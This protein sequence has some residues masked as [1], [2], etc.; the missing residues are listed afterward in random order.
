M[1]G[2]K[3]STTTKMEDGARNLLYNGTK[4]INK[5]LTIRKLLPHASIIVSTEAP[6]IQ[7]L[8][9]LGAKKNPKKARKQT[10]APW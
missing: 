2:N 4:S 7:N 10:T 3:S 8:Y 5:S 6:K 1:S 9:F